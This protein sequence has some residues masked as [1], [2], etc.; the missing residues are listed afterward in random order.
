MDPRVLV[1]RQIRLYIE[2]APVFYPV[3][4]S[5]GFVIVAALLWPFTSDNRALLVVWSGL[6]VATLLARV[7]GWVA[8]ARARPGDDAVGP[9]LKWFLVPQ[10]LSVIVIGSGPFFFLP[11]GSGRDFDILLILSTAVFLATFGSS[12]KLSAYRPAIPLV[13]T[14]LVVVYAAGVL[15]VPGS[16][17]KVLALASVF[18][19]VFG[20]LLASRVN[21]AF[22]RSME[23]SIRNE[24]LVLAAEQ[25]RQAAERAEREKTR[26]L[27]A[28]SHDLRQPMHAISLLVGMLQ[29]RAPEADRAVMRRLE[30]S[31]EAM[32][33]LFATIL[34]LSKLDSGAVHPSVAEVPLRAILDSIELHFAPEAA[35]KR[36]AL[37]VFRSRAVVRTDRAL[38]E[39]VVRNLVS[40]AIKYTP[41][42]TVL[43]GC[44]RRGERLLIGVWDTGV[45]IA[46]ADLDRIFDEFFQAAPAARDRG[47]GL[48]LSIAHR[49]ARLLKSKIDVASTPGRGSS[50][51]LA[52]PFVAYQSTPSHHHDAAPDTE[53]SL[54][55]K[56][57]LVVDDDPQAC[58]G[59]EALLRQWGCHAASAAS[60]E[61][62]QAA[63]E[64]EL[65]FPD[66]IVTD[67]RLGEGRTGLEVIAAVRSYTGEET[68]A[69]IVTGEEG[70]DTARLGHPTIRKPV[71]AGELRKC[72][73]SV[74]A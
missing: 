60:L 17:P 74:A 15:Q 28:A 24:Q 49:L 63:L 26:F 33:S 55:G 10:I 19:G 51:G 70:L 41:A 32:D 2:N 66:A 44:R 21:Q 36:L 52:V 31:V 67:Y 65:R 45:G 1:A 38:L 73:V 71:S 27:A 69:V 12:L 18:C 58:F 61:A 37:R 23:L 9:W 6:I 46:R 34:D 7:L 22:V 3:S 40:N 68:A 64:R 35:A 14:P 53:P 30:H 13:L 56:F 43:V 72:L 47:Q 8:Y 50:F 59:T 5:V 62:V 11:S 57:I 29:P 20:W 42:G 48:G 4:I 54:A 16:V 39:R 25:A